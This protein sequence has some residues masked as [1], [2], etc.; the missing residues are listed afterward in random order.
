MRP[1]T[2]TGVQTKML[3]SSDDVKIP[4]PPTVT[5]DGVGLAA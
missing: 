5:G 1:A 4:D 2:T 3:S